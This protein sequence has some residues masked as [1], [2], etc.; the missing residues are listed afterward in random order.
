MERTPGIR[1]SIALAGTS[2]L[3]ALLFNWLVWGATPGLGLTVYVGLLI[4]GFIGLALYM[5]GAIPT[6]VYWLLGLLAVF[7]ALISIRDNELLVAMNMLACVLLMLVTIEA[8]ARG[9]IRDFR[10]L[11]Y[12]ARLFPPFQWIDTLIRTCADVLSARAHIRSERATAI[13][14]GILITV[15]VVAVF[16]A[17]L[18]SADPVF[19][20]FFADIFALNISEEAIGHIVVTTIIA[21]ILIA[22]Y[23]FAFT[24]ETRRFSHT[25]PRWLGHLEGM[26]LFGSINLLFLAFIIVQIT[27]FF[28]GETN[29]TVAGLTYAE[30]ARRG[31]FE[32]LAIAG[33]SY[34]L[35]LAAESFIQRDS[36]DHA[37]TFQVLSVATVLQVGV[38]MTSSFMRLSLYEQ[39]FGFTTLR[40]YSHAFILFLAVVFV[41]LLYK[42]AY[43]TREHTFALRTFIATVAFVLCMNA[44][45]PDAF[46]ASKNLARYQAT[47]KIDTGYLSVL[48]ADAAGVLQRIFD[49]TERDAKAEVGKTLL[50][51]TSAT[52]ENWQSWNWS[53]SDAQ[54]RLSTRLQDFAVYKDTQPEVTAPVE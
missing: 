52:P 32:L 13:T 2:V 22:G 4:A 23:S 1:G 33:L 7:A 8:Y 29:I 12:L 17:L 44:F 48:S 37:V 20:R 51:I 14:R 9:G 11:D 50:R 49:S 18:S 36:E 19:G 34:L 46:I 45:N 38:I 3:L 5:R 26:I 54:T 10:P 16:A 25:T 47:G 21:V 30:Y 15:P 6:D 42:I 41:I 27:Y 28:G 24:G 40:L 31:F 39:A 53:R 35:L 43:D